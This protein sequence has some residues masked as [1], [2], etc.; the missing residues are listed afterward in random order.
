DNGDAAV[1]VVQGAQVGLG[2]VGGGEK[3]PVLADGQVGAVDM[4][5]VVVVDQGPAGAG[6]ALWFFF[7]GGLN[8]RRPERVDDW[9]GGVSVVKGV[10]AAVGGEVEHHGEV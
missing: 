3:R 2:G 6:A 5:G 8:E 10:A 4:D 7:R 9:L 1:F